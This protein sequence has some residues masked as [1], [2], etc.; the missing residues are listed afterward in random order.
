MSNDIE[1]IKHRLNIVDV[2][3]SYLHLKKMGAG[4]KGLC[5]FHQEKTPSFNVNEE[6][7]IF[8]CFGC[9]EAGDV[10]DFVQKMEHLTFPEVLQL[11]ADR[12][13]VILDRTK[14]PAIF[15]KE[16]DEKSRLYALNR[17]AAQVFHKILLEHPKAATARAYLEERGMTVATIKEFQ[18]GYAPPAVRHTPPP[19]EQLLLQRGFR[20]SE[21]TNAG[22]PERFANRLMFPLWDALGNPIGFT[23]RAL[24]AEDQPKYLNTP[25]TPIF[26]K[27]RILYPLHRAKEAIKRDQRSILVEG[28]MDVL[29]AHQ[30]GTQATVATSG[31]ALTSDHLVILRRYTPK[32]ALAFDSDAAGIEATRKAILLA[33]D[34]EMEPLVIVLP[35]GVKD[36]GELALSDP[37]AWT[38]ALDKALPAF[39]WQLETALKQVTDAASASGKKAIA[40][41]LLPVLVRMRDPIE[42]AHWIQ[43]VARRLH[44]ADRTIGEAI[45][46]HIAKSANGEQRIA[47]RNPTPGVGVGPS[48]AAERLTPDGLLLGLLL[49]FPEHLVQVAAKIDL[50]DFMAES[51]EQR[52]AKAISICY[53]HQ[54]QTERTAFEQA[55]KAT[56]DAAD[57]RWL[58]QVLA[59]IERLHAA[60]DPAQIRAEIDAGL[61]RLHTRQREALKGSM[62]ERIAAAEGTGD[63]QAVQDLLKELQHMLKENP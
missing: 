31:T 16:K 37:L 41:Q 4:W 11:L 61:A 40:A 7:Q 36:L 60:S 50:R 8:K 20:R 54:G 23:G 44:V 22:S 28:Q 57:R 24:A 12:A 42:R 34:L 55:V 15:A 63:R 21:L 33:Y 53:T 17:L 46:R 32:V 14:T 59:E 56:L 49:Y 29:L 52:L 45:D 18:L 9:N 6:R 3:Q 39:T 51:K 2:A 43:L 13:G 27:G 62:A 35:A 5:P 38:A 10:F 25:E 26:K 58:D 1:D 48:P 47:Q 19:L 30:L